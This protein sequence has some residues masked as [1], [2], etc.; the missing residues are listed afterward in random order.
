MV[1]INYKGLEIT[2]AVLYSYVLVSDHCNVLSES[3][4]GKISN[5]FVP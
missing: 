4:K 5:D 3:L 1:T 2:I